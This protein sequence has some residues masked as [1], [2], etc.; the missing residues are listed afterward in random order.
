M[1]SGVDPTDGIVILV[2]QVETEDRCDVMRCQP[3][4]ESEDFD[5]LGILERVERDVKE[6]WPVYSDISRSR[7]LTRVDYL[8][9]WRVGEYF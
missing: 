6:L 3:V 7:G 4:D 1:L 9:C 8:T 5:D 2:P